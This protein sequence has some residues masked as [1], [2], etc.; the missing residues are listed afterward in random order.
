VFRPYHSKLPLDQPPTDLAR[1]YEL[2]A[3]FRFDCM[4]TFESGP[5]DF[6]T[7]DAPPFERDVRIQFFAALARPGEPGGDTLVL[8]READVQAGGGIHED[9]MPSD[10]PMF[11]QL[12]SVHGSG[13]V[14]RRVLRVEDGPAHVPGFNATRF[15]IGTRCVGCHRG[16]SVLPVP[17]NYATA[18]RFN[19]SPSA[20]VTASSVAP[21]TP[22]EMAAVD[23]RARGNPVQVGWIANSKTGEWVRLEWQTVIEVDTLIL[24]ALRRRWPDSDLN[25][26]EVEVALFRGGQPVATERVRSELKPLGTRIPLRGTRADALEVRPLRST[27][28][29]LGRPRVGIAEIETRARI[30]VDP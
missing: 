19:A 24:Y 16:H 28:N 27:G 13:S 6:P 8:V 30:A 10:I 21:G 20:R 14:G 5:V 1:A 25:V 3:S 2:G 26:R 23:R 9:A 17:D 7:P 4:N 11:E 18:L 29:V 15:G 22:G 12:V